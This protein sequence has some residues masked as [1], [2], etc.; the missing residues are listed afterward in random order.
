MRELL[1]GLCFLGCVRGSP[2][3]ATPRP[4]PRDHLAQLR[5]IAAGAPLT[6]HVDPSLGLLVVEQVDPG[7]GPGASEVRHA[8]RNCG[9]RLAADDAAV[10]LIRAGL[11]QAESLGVSC[12]GARCT[13]QGMEFAPVYRFVFEGDRLTRIERRSEANLSPSQREGRDAW[14]RS[15]V[16]DQHARRCRP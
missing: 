10:A 12:E 4:A 5:A 15:L 2:A 9:A 11:S 14:V 16:D 8:R 7:P 1:C 13:V 3:P 6:E